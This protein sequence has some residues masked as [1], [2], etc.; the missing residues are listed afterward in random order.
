MLWWWQRRV[1]R[2]VVWVPVKVLMTVLPGFENWRMK[3][4]MALRGFW[5]LLSAFCQAC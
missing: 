1:A 2:E 4:F 3:H 5:L